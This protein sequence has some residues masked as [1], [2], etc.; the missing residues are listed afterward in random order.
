MQT[1]Y[2][3]E[4]ILESQLDQAD[5]KVTSYTLSCSRALLVNLTLT[6]VYEKITRLVLY[7]KVH[8]CVYKNLLL[9][10]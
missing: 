8:C 2:W 5:G 3:C 1:E 9:D 4:N 7:P 10:Y 6:C